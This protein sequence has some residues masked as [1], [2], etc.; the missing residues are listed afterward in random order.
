M[1]PERVSGMHLF[2]LVTWPTQN[3]GDTTGFG[4]TLLIGA[5]LAR[6]VATVPVRRFSNS[7][8]TAEI[9]FNDLTCGLTCWAIAISL[10]ALSFCQQ[11]NRVSCIGKRF[12]SQ[13]DLL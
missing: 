8:N 12:S 7:V 4:K 2:G 11:I 6:T 13:A 9:E 5:A 10:S 1:S 3:H